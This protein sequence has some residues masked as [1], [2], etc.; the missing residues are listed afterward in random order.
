MT[1]IRLETCLCRAVPLSSREL[2]D[3]VRNI[4]SGLGM[5]KS[6][7]DILITGDKEMKALNRQFLAMEG[8]T[9]VLS[10]PDLNGRTKGSLGQLVINIDSVRREAFLYHQQPLTHLVRLLVHG[11]LHLAGFEHGQEMDE[12]S[13]K[14]IHSCLGS[15]FC[16]TYLQHGG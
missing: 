3:I 8:P 5:D 4:L 15:N 14:L 12:T 10:F 7:L 2:A 16:S 11:M 13:D 9:N 6:N 1:S